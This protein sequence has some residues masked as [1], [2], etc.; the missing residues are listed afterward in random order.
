MRKTRRTATL[1]CI[2]AVVLMC[3]ACGGSKG[4][5]ASSAKVSAPNEFPIVEEQETL[6]IFTNKPGD[7][8]DMELN[9]FTKWYE[10]KTN[11]KVKWIFATGDVRRA[12]YI[13]GTIL[14][15]LC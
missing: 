1:A 9:A 4:G 14:T 10:E 12:I 13:R 6:T 3:T 8:E 7:V 5:S 2:L 15:E 11:V